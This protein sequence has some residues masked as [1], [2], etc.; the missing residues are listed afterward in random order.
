[1]DKFTHKGWF[2]ICP[3][4]VQFKTPGMPL[5]ESRHVIF[6]PLM[7]ISEAWYMV[8]FTVLGL[9]C[10]EYEPMWPILITGE[11]DDEHN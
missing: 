3:V 4:Y 10:E 11:V 5:L 1:M 9:L 6:E 2:G 7:A 8:K